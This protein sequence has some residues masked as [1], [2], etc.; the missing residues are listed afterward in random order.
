MTCITSKLLEHVICSNVNAFLDEHNLLAGCQHGFRKRHGCD[1]QLLATTTELV[2]SYDLN[3]PIDLAV[4]DFSKAF[5]VV[6]HKKLL[7]KIEAIG[8]H[9]STCTWIYNWLCNRTISVY[10]NGANSSKHQVTSGVPQGSVLGPLL[11]LIFINDM[12]SSV[13]SC[14]LSLFADDSL[15]YHQVKTQAD[16]DKLQ[17]ADAL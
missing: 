9:Q 4:L 10:V 17:M 16:V 3:I 11:F 14:S 13:E 15:M 7:S 1:T 6:S 8:I 2:S 12:P 5:D